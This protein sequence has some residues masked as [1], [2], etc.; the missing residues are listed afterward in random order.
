MAAPRKFWDRT[1]GDIN[2]RSKYNVN[3]VAVR[4]APDSKG[5]VLVE[6]MPCAE[7]VVAEGDVLILVGRDEDIEAVAKL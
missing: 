5:R 6:D 2:L 1:L 3:L 7:T 4:R